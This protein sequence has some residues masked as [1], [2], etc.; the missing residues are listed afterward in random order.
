METRSLGTPVAGINK[1]QSEKSDWPFPF[2]SARVERAPPPAAVGVAF[3][4]V[5]FHPQPPIVLRPSHQPPPHRILPNVFQFLRET[6]FRPQHVIKR[7][8]LP[9]RPRPS[10]RPIQAVCGSRFNPLQNLHQA[11]EI[12]IRIPQRTE[13]KMHMVRH[14]HD[15]MN[16]SLSSL[17]MQ[18]MPKHYVPDRFRQWI[19]ATAKRNKH[20]PIILLT[21]RKPPTISVSPLQ[22]CLSHKYV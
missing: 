14:N 11:I 7:L 9:H 19:E 15:R 20:S 8:F 1:S 4:P 22:Q 3:A 16:R 5:L 2:C 18:T 6:F 12:A 17:I 13:Q 21:M 10:Q